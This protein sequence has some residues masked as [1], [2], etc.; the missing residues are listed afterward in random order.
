MRNHAFFCL[1]G[2]AISSTAFAQETSLGDVARASRA[3]Q[4]SSRKEAQVFS[5]EERTPQS[6]KDGED[7]LEVFTRARDGFLHDAPHRCEEEGSGN[8]GPGWQRSETYEVAA[9]DRMRLVTQDGGPEEN[10][11]SRAGPTT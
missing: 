5:N 3:R 7:P 4:A 10:S 6:I 9:A 8:S 11:F 1:L 2:L